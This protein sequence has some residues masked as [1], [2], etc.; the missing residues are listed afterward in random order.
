MWHATSVVSGANHSNRDS[1]RS[2]CWKVHLNGSQNRLVWMCV[3]YFRWRAHQTPVAAA[4]APAPFTQFSNYHN[5]RR[6]R[7]SISSSEN[8]VQTMYLCICVCVSMY[9]CVCTVGKIKIYSTNCVVVCRVL[10]YVFS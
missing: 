9:A 4:E 1:L 3:S 10:L 7:N 2:K 5:K 8:N 6:K